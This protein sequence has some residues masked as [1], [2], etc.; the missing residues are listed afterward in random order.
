[1][2][3]MERWGLIHICTTLIAPNRS[4]S[5][6]S[7]TQPACPENSV[8]TRSQQFVNSTLSSLRW[9]DRFFNAG[10]LLCRALPNTI[11]SMPFVTDHVWKTPSV[12][13]IDP[14]YMLKLVDFTA[15]KRLEG[16][17]NRAHLN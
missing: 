7:T 1:M 16:L 3:T 4:G 9:L 10:K 15:P 5:I 12:Y 8:E 6:V 14:G 11:A 13:T 2:K 17:N